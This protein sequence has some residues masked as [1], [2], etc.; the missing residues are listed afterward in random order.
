[1]FAVLLILSCL[2]VP[3]KI[4][5]I[6]QI[7]FYFDHSLAQYFVY[8]GGISELITSFLGQFFYYPAIGS[9]ILAGL[10]FLIFYFSFKILSAFFSTR[11]NFYLS[12]ILPF[13]FLYLIKNPAFPAIYLT[14]LTFS[15]I[16]TWLFIKS[17]IGNRW[18]N[19]GIISAMFMLLIYIASFRAAL[20]FAAIILLYMIFN[21]KEQIIPSLIGLI[22]VSFAF[23]ELNK[24]LLLSTNEILFT[25]REIFKFDYQD[26]LR[27]NLIFFYLPVITLLL[28]TAGKKILKSSN[29]LLPSTNILPSAILLAVLS[30]AVFLIPLKDQNLLPDNF[31]YLSYRQEWNKILQK[32]KKLQSQDRIVVYYTDKA[33]YYTGGMST[34]LFKYPQDWGE[35]ALFLTT[36]T[37]PTTLMDNSDLFYELGHIGAAR[38]WA[39]EAQTVFENR[40]NILQRLIA[41]NIIVGNYSAASSFALKLSHSL[42]HRQE[43]L[44]YLS[45]INDTNLI[46]NDNQLMLKRSLMPKFDFFLRKKNPEIELIH[47]LDA[48]K[49][50]RMAYEYYQAYNLLHN[51]VIKVV[52]NIPGMRNIGFN[53]VPRLYEEAAITYYY[54]KNINADTVDGYKISDNTR[55]RF[56]NYLKTLEY[57]NGNFEL[58]REPLKETYGDTYWYYLHFVSPITLKKE[59]TVEYE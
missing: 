47:L 34:D 56:N 40:P 10:L 51:D 23:I 54:T 16:F 42:L 3:Q 44:Y 38:Y 4:W 6:Q 29:N 37:E 19:A 32:A 20:L 33:L 11:A 31:R 25:G 2:I 15:L 46:K 45:L 57:A 55:Y 24:Y 39:F 53:F 50:N 1:M 49:N 21:R 27:I 43:A 48:N 5:Y 12:L 52:K 26:T 35:Y 59:I 28:I 18:T 17:K 30:V 41:T 7:V 22:I 9:L 14:Q 13:A 58:A 36:L 8:A